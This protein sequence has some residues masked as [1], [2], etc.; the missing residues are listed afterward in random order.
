MMK[1]S[2]FIVAL[3]GFALVACKKEASA[4]ADANVDSTEVVVEEEAPAA[5]E[6]AP[7]EEAAAPAEGEAAAPAEGEAAAK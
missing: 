3:A 6:A 1:K 7:A 2:L 5:E 4:D